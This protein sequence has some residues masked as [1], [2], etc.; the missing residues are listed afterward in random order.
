MRLFAFYVI[1]LYNKLAGTKVYEKLQG[2]LFSANMK[3][4]IP[5]LS[6]GQQTSDLEG[7][8]SVTNHFAPKMHGFSYHGQLCR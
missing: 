2:I 8:H 6:P 4:D 3:K 7:Y 1:S 5:M